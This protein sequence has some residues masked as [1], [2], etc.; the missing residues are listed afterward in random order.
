MKD[1]LE[2]L[3]NEQSFTVTF[4]EPEM[5]KKAGEAVAD[6]VRIV[7]FERRTLVAAVIEKI[8]ESPAVD[9]KFML[10]NVMLVSVRLVTLCMN[11]VDLLLLFS[12]AKSARTTFETLVMLIPALFALNTLFVA[13][14][15]THAREVKLENFRAGV[16][17]LGNVK[18]YRRTSLTAHDAPS[19]ERFSSGIVNPLSSR[20]V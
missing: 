10:V 2:F 20:E 11:I 12:K 15:P 13:R 8:E 3:L 4:E 7:M 17:V 9:M 18:S 5:A 19:I 14:R 6:E 16:N 1:I